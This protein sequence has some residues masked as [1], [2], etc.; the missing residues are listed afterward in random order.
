MFWSYSHQ[1]KLAIESRSRRNT[2]FFLLKYSMS[3]WQY[4]S[5]FESKTY[6]EDLHMI[7][8]ILKTI[9]RFVNTIKKNRCSHKR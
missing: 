4:G 7:C 9:I 3:V 6:N 5:Q 8:V 1:K 2:K